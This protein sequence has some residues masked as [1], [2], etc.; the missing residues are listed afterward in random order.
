M[1][2]ESAREAFIRK[3]Y[4]NFS[5][6]KLAEKI[7]YSPGTIYQHFNN[8]EDLLHCLVDEGFD[9]LLEV[10]EKKP[11][12]RD[13]LRS[14]KSKLKSYIDFGLRHP[15]HYRFA[16]M[17]RPAGG[18]V[19]H[20][21]IPHPVFD[22]LRNAVRR[23]VVEKQIQTTDVETTSQVLWA[24]IHGI[25]SLLIIRPDFPWVNK[26]KLIDRLLDT[27]LDGLRRK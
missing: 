26:K 14:L 19:R 4:E 9:K 22:V 3:G 25:T 2:L 6:R 17:M 1:I 7:E 20:R 11:E 21:K 16:F 23:C 18:T 15:N 13:S 10:L 24:S 27:T 5:M 8:K 12:G